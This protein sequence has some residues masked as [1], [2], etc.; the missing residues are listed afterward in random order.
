MN[1]IRCYYW[2]ESIV[3]HTLKWLFVLFLMLTSFNW[4]YFQ[5]VFIFQIF[6]FFKCYFFQW[7]F[8]S[9][10]QKFLFFQFFFFSK[11]YFFSKNHLFEMF[12]FSFPRIIF[13]K[14]LYLFINNYTYI[15]TLF[16]KKLN[17]LC[18][19]YYLLDRKH[20]N[21]SINRLFCSN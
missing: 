6:S 4:Y 11:C 2:L 9:F 5:C 21:A 16:I 7:S 10:F 8:F 13:I 3:M 17:S 15:Q 18:C 20:C 19:Y 14:K 12:F 1:S